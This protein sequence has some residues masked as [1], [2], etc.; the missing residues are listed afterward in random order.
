MPIFSVG[1]ERTDRV[2]LRG[3]IRVSASTKKA[4]IAHVLRMI[5]REDE[6]LGAELSEFD[7]GEG[8]VE[9]TG[10]YEEQGESSS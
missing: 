10:S 5:E 9:I 3:S 6:T 4:A 8:D 7:S 1:I 2:H